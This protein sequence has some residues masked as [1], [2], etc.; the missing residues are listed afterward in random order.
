MGLSLC[1]RLELI[2]YYREVGGFRYIFETF[3]DLLT[4]QKANDT[5]SEFVREK[6]R[7]IVQ[8]EETAEALCPDHP[9]MGKRPPLGHHYFETF[10][11]PSVELVNI[12]D[13]PIKEITERGV[14]TGTNEYEVDMIIY[15]IGFDASTGAYTQM[16][17]RGRNNRCLGD[18][19]N[20]VLETFLGIGVEGYP[21]FFM[22][23]APQSPFANLPVVLDNSADWI[24]KA[25]SYMEKHGY[26]EMEPKK[27]AQEQWV[28]LLTDTYEATVLPE[29]AKKA[30]SWY[31]GANIPGKAV[32]PLFWFGGVV[33]YFQ[34]CDGEAD[35]DF[36][37][38]SFT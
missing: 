16:D 32:R 24:G 9:L 36:P 13:N 8:D 20:K 18:E 37:G 30:G 26:K 19:W 17:I 25:I 29:A 4:N 34:I 1:G 31:I 22:L 33:S 3:T 28:K 10:N 7:T 12:K 15:A 6:I 2:P 5:A 38:L 23:S 14:R 27:E 21:S 35:K 11:K